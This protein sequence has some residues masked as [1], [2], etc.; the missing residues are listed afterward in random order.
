[1]PLIHKI[2]ESDFRVGVWKITEGE[3]FFSNKL[4]FCSIIKSTVQK[5]QYMATRLILTELNSEFLI[6]DIDDWS[7][8]KPLYR[9]NYFYF[10]ISHTSNMA[11]A[12]LSTSKHVGID[13]ELISGRISSLKGHFLNNH[14][15]ELLEYID[16][17]N[18]IEVISLFW[19]VKEAVLKWIGD[20]EFDYLYCIT[21]QNY[22]LNNE[23][24]INV[25][26]DNYEIISVKVKYFKLDNYWIS[27]CV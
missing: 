26:L 20:S 17:D 13:I 1:M 4:G 23:N 11:V 12:I 18:L 24:I 7:Q 2:E 21:I 10:N 9:N 27:F 3:S 15:L 6:G 8:N 19:T 22:N 14:E 5:M 25:K 16:S